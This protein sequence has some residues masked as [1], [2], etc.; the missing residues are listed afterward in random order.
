[1]VSEYSPPVL[2]T[3]LQ[4]LRRWAAERGKQADSVGRESMKAVTPNW[5]PGWRSTSRGDPRASRVLRPILGSGP[6]SEPRP[7]GTA[8]GGHAGSTRGDVAGEAAEG[9]ECRCHGPRRA[10]QRR[11]QPVTAC[12]NG[13]RDPPSSTVAGPPRPP[14]ARGDRASLT[15]RRRA[16][17]P[18]DE[19]GEG[20]AGRPPPT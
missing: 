4:Q 2:C 10:E 14:V 19:R 6:L 7:G 13:R 16:G 17:G 11:Q 8:G 20:D 9:P 12:G 3:V 15:N 5:S 18:H 1:M